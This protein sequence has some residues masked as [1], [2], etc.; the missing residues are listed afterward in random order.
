VVRGWSGEGNLDDIDLE[1]RKQIKLFKGKLKEDPIKFK[2]AAEKPT[3]L[4]FPGK[5]LADPESKRIFIADSTNHRIVIT[6]LEGKKIAIAGSGKEGFKDGKFAD[7]QFSDPQGMALDGDTLYVA[8][9]K[10]HSIRALDLK[11]ETVKIA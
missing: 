9:R 4:M 8:D 7:A 3:P 1:I 2:L 5:V 10:N 11:K 6:N